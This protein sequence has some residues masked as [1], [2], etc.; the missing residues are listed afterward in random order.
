VTPAYRF[1]IQDD[2]FIE[3]QFIQPLPARKVHRGRMTFSCEE[4][5]VYTEGSTHQ[6]WTI[7]KRCK[8]R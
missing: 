6:T 7:G 8:L 2:P 1:L 5:G 3:V 4:I